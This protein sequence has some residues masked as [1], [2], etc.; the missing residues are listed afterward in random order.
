[1]KV[2]EGIERSV[3]K[4][5]ATDPI[6]KRFLDVTNYYGQSVD[7]DNQGRLLIQPLLREAVKATGMVNVLGA[8]DHLELANAQSFTEDVKAPDGSMGLTDA[9]QEA[10]GVKTQDSQ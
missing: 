8:L 1:M 7:M 5:A 4:L 10:F 6:R 2:W 3:L 9:E